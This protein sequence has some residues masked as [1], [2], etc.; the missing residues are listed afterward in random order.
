MTLNALGGIGR[1]LGRTQVSQ[2]KEKK[3]FVL[4]QEREEK[5]QRCVRLLLP[6]AERYKIVRA[7]K[8]E[9]VSF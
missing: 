8:Y 9:F 6:P 4:P 5:A 1:N 7:A 3:H 2:A